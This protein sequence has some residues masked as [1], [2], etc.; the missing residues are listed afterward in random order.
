MIISINKYYGTNATNPSFRRMIAYSR[1]I[2]TEND[3]N[4]LYHPIFVQYVACNKDGIESLRL[5]SHGNADRPYTATLPA[6]LTQIKVS[7]ALNNINDVIVSFFY[8]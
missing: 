7:L 8:K 3:P 2:L 6:V 5:K 4:A 1:Q